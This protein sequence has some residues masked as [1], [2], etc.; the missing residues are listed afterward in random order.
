MR[1]VSYG[2]TDVGLKREGNEDNYICNDALGLF[3]VADGMGGH[4]AGEVA[5]KTAVDTLSEF[6]RKH[7]EENPALE[8][9]ESIEHYVSIFEDGV[10]E[11]NRAICEMSNENAGMN[12]MGT[13]F[14]GF[15]VNQ[16]QAAMAHVGDSRIYR[17]RDGDF[18]TLTIDHSWVQE[19]LERNI[20]TPEEAKV[21]RWRNVI[22][23]ALGN[24]T[25]LEVDTDVIEFLPGD[26][27]LMCSD[28]LTGMVDDEML[29]GMLA[30]LG[31]DLEDA[32]EAMI[33]KANQ[34]GGEDNI[35]LVLLRIDEE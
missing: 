7:L 33:K 15:L 6:I 12:G 17:L 30:E 27:Y 21:H 2:Q 28:G 11:A 19:Q 32:G 31:H 9:T 16:D 35:T 22:T 10:Q 5:S 14:S 23:R 29:G 25:I 20:I 3:A 26:R 18:A 4:V 1:I 8:Q 34:A 13:T 24:R